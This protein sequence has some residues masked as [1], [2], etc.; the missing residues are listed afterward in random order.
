MQ[1]ENLCQKRLC[2][3][4]IKNSIAS[5]ITKGSDYHQATIIQP[6]C[7]FCRQPV[8]KAVD[9][10]NLKVHDLP[11][12]LKP[13]KDQTLLKAHQN[14]LIFC[15]EMD[16]DETFSN[17]EILLPSESH[18]TNSSNKILVSHTSW[19]EIWETTW[20][21]YSD[22]ENNGW[23]SPMEVLG[24]IKTK[25]TKENLLDRSWLPPIYGGT[26]IL[27]KRKKRKTKKKRV[28]KE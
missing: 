13:R 24:G 28:N 10:E 20:K 17:W 23:P 18:K 3:S 2:F 9:V 5:Q 4:C 16:D 8:E 12:F 14:K 7:P 6:I 26:M 1:K 27:P 21:F 22:G 11:S 15:I 25:L 19:K